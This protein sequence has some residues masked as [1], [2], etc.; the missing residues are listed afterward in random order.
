MFFF[1]LYKRS[2]C[3]E[4]DLSGKFGHI[5]VGRE[6]SFFTKSFHT[7]VDLE[8]P[9]LDGHRSVYLVLFEQDSNENFL[10]CAKIRTIQRKVARASF[11]HEGVRGAM[12]FD[13]V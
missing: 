13:Q 8:L 12:I 7:D 3:K 2:K 11:S 10:S 4:G 6:E 5:K 9:E 1:P